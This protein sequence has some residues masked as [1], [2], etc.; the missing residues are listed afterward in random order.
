MPKPVNE[1]VNLSRSGGTG[2]NYASSSAAGKSLAG[3]RVE[4]GANNGASLPLVHVV[5]ATCNGRNWIAEQVDTI[6]AQ[7]NVR[8]HLA[9]SD[10]H[11]TDGTYLW[12]Q[13]LADRDERVTLLPLREGRPGVAQNFFYAVSQ[14]TVRAGEYMAFADQDDLWQPDKLAQQIELLELAG[15][16]AVSSNVVAFNATGM[17]RKICKDQP[18]RKWDYLF[19]S[20][21]PGSTFVLAD[22]A[23]WVVQDFLRGGMDV[24]KMGFSKA[25]K[26]GFSGAENA[27]LDGAENAGDGVEN[28]GVTRAQNAGFGRAKIA[29]L[30]KVAL[31]DWF[32]YALVRSSRMR[33]L[34]D[35]RPHVFYRQ[36][37]S[38]HL[39][40]SIGLHAMKTRLQGLHSGFYREQFQV[41]ALA[42]WSCGK[43]FQQNRRWRAQIEEI[44]GLLAD[45][46]FLSRV[47]LAAKW[48]ALRRRPLEGLALAGLLIMGWW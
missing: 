15:V 20:A 41:V 22:Q 9:I 28:A 47:R 29:L 25:E 44:R 7:R 10:D 45:R 11:S 21:G 37:D 1:E 39:G 43:H 38:N 18:Q 42:A 27:K 31:H 4:S 26:T 46:S 8:V 40:A 30:G 34:I 23:A 33:W 12:L 3:T 14:V 16:A 48:R 13:Q 2:S 32:I 36:H 24:K 35:P 19:E 5:I 6:L 17:R